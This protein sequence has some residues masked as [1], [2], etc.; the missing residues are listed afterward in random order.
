MSVGW[1][2]EMLIFD[3]HV[4]VLVTCSP[5]HDNNANHNHHSLST[6]P[7]SYDWFT[8][9]HWTITSHWVDPSEPSNHSKLPAAGVNHSQPF[10][11]TTTSVRPP[12]NSSE[13]K[14]DCLH[15]FH[16]YMPSTI[17]N[18]I[19]HSHRSTLDP[20]SK[21][22][23]FELRTINDAPIIQHDQMLSVI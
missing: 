21:K 7:K 11:T 12:L 15:T 14:H 9:I 4:G 2:F 17:Y 6:V 10:L 8:S 22:R 3:H 1:A 13:I 18:W 23:S 16:W 19:N 5:H 20:S